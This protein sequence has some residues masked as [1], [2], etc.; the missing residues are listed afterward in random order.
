MEGPVLPP[1]Q[2]RG[3]SAD[4]ATAGPRSAAEPDG[5]EPAV[6]L[7]YRARHTGPDAFTARRAR[8]DSTTTEDAAGGARPAA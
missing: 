8:G 6:R 3:G 2:A 4:G 7:R 1:R 5:G